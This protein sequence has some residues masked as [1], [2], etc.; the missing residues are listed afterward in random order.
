ME[1]LSKFAYTN[2]IFVVAHRGSSG[3]AP[4]NTLA[5]FREAIAL[6][7]KMI[8]TDIQ[9]TSD[10]QIVVY[11]DI[12]HILGESHPKS[13]EPMTFE[14]LRSLDAGSW[15]SDKFAGEKIPVLKE[16][17]EL[18]KDKTY[19]IIEIKPQNIVNYEQNLENLLNEIIDTGTIDQTLFASFS[20]SFLK[21]IKS[22]NPAFHTAA[23]KLPFDNRL[24]SEIVT[25][26]GCEAFICALP[27]LNHRIS[28]DAKTNKIFLGVYS[29]NSKEDL[30]DVLKYH[31]NAIGTDFPGLIMKE[32]AQLQ[33]KFPSPLGEGLR[34][35]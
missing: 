23:V 33:N 7:V 34:V 24:P 32:L 3:T 30:K 21:Y 22:K 31:I 35:R 5:A 25:E 4:E 29:I 9:F 28:D 17:L 12:A 2:D 1:T 6:N 20:Y 11:H 16:V 27:E 10:G 13:D 26:T 19:I 14:E 8:E 18:T 15:F